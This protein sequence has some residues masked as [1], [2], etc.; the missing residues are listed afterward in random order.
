MLSGLGPES[1]F[2]HDRGAPTLSPEAISKGDVLSQQFPIY[3]CAEVSYVRRVSDGHS[4]PP[5]RVAHHHLQATQV[6][7]PL[8]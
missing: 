7:G 6:I 3:A 4:N 5:Q 8:T 1:Y 2:W